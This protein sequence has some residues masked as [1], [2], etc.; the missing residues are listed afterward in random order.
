MVLPVCHRHTH[1]QRL[2]VGRQAGTG[3]ESDL[4]WQLPPADRYSSGSS[5]NRP[6]GDSRQQPPEMRSRQALPSASSK[7]LVL[8]LHLRAAVLTTGISQASLY[9]LGG[10]DGLSEGSTKAHQ[11]PLSPSACRAWHWTCLKPLSFGPCSVPPA[12]PE[13]AVKPQDHAGAQNPTPSS[14]KDL[15]VALGPLIPT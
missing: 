6:G 5:R 2:L 15:P 14:H 12:N 11:P 1:S 9:T 8:H 13:A 4:A 3:C 7:N 10:R